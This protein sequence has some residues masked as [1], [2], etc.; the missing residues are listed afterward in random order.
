MFGRAERSTICRQPPAPNSA[1]REET[2]RPAAQTRPPIFML[3]ALRSGTTVFRLMLNAHEEISNPGEFDFIFDYLMRRSNSNDWVYDLGRLRR[4]RIFQSQGLEILNT[5]DGRTIAQNFVD[6]LDR[7]TT[8][9]LCLNIHGNAD[10]AAAVFPGCR[11]IHIIRD[12]RDVAPSVVGMGWAGNTY[13]GIDQWLETETNWNSSVSLFDKQSTIEIRFEN[14]MANPQ[15]EL[16]RVC[17]FIGVPFSPAML[18]YNAQS[19]YAPP[20]PSAIERWKTKLSS[21]EVAL[22]E[23]KAKSL[24]L[25]RNYELSGYGLDSP[26]LGEKF[27]LIWTN[28]IYK[29][30]F[31]CRR[32][33]IVTF[34][35]EAI[36]RRLLK[37]L[38]HVFAQ[39]INE[40]DK[41]YLK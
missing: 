38:H 1:S 34:L 37:P 9:V 30:K 27:S 29:W 25:Q 20:D 18:N 12:P 31:R 39:R 22:V 40:I 23:I 19:T 13:F 36:T 33:G 11:I 8:G 6:Q 10:K 5:E 4:D 26:S 32:Y 17:K 2:R 21:R 24:L 41:Q 15:A 28:K 3:G 35:L 14:L 7:R 16:E